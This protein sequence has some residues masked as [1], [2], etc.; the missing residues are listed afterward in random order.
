MVGLEPRTLWSTVHCHIH[1]TTTPL[2][3]WV[4]HVAKRICGIDW[5]KQRAIYFWNTP[6]DRISCTVIRVLYPSPFDPSF[7]VIAIA[8]SSWN[9]VASLRMALTTLW[10]R[11][12]QSTT[13]SF[14][15]SCKNKTWEGTRSTRPRMEAAPVCSPL[16][17]WPPWTLGSG[18]RASVPWPR[19]SGVGQTRCYVRSL[20]VPPTPSLSRHPFPSRRQGQIRSSNLVSSRGFLSSLMGCCTKVVIDCK[21]HNVQ[22]IFA[23]DSNSTFLQRPIALVS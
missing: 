19:P 12:T 15:T 10:W 21:L 2:H 8:C 11:T 23:I 7:S 16:S 22:L 13:H 17:R 3:F 4:I 5:R 1:S 14:R 6:R 18:Q 9:P 20:P